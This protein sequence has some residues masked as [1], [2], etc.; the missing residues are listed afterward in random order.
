MFLK[1]SLFAHQLQTNKD[2]SLSNHLYSGFFSLDTLHTQFSFMKERRQA[3]RFNCSVALHYSVLAS[4]EFSEVINAF[5]SKRQRMVIYDQLHYEN[6]KLNFKLQSIESDTAPALLSLNNQLGLLTE[7]ISMD[8]DPLIRQTS[9]DIV[10]STTGMS[11]NVSNMID[12]GNFIEIQLRMTNTSPRIL[13]LGEVV[14]C[15]LL[16]DTNFSQYLC[17]V[18]FTFLDIEDK[19]RLKYFVN[20]H[21]VK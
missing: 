9:S 1:H 2:K 6:T 3:S 5:N 18:S 11:F 16:E 12:I 8:I 19:E 21:I 4:N 7:L 10:I 15:T 14:K 17:A 20:E 13:I